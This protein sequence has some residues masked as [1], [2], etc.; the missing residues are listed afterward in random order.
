MMLA[1]VL[2]LHGV[3]WGVAW[4]HF[5]RVQIGMIVPFSPAK[6]IFLKDSGH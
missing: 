4:V 2:F 1:S 3:R 5:D 6:T